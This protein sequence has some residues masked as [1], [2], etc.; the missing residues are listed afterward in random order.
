MRT[1]HHQKF[2]FLLIAL[3]ILP[4]VLH[5]PIW[6]SIISIALVFYKSLGEFFPIPVPRRIFL[7][8]AALVSTVLVYRHF[9]T[10]AGD[11]ASTALLLILVSLKLF[12]VR[13]YRD[14]MIMI[15]LCFFLLLTK[16]LADQSIPT[17]IYLV[18]DVILIL[19]FLIFCHSEGQNVR[20]RHLFTHSAGLVTLSLPILLGLFFIFPRFSF[21]LFQSPQKSVGRV[22]LS[23]EMD[24]GSISSVALSDELIFRAYFPGEATPPAMSELY[25]RAAILDQGRGLSWR[26]SGTTKFSEERASQAPALSETIRQEIIQEPSGNRFLFGMDWP[27]SLRVSGDAR[28]RNAARRPGGVFESTLPIHDRLY[29]EVHS[30]GQAIETIRTP[31]LQRYLDPGPLTESERSALQ[32]LLEEHLNDS[33]GDTTT[34]RVKRLLQYFSEQGFQYT[35][36]PGTLQSLDEFLFEAQ[37]GFCEHYAAATATILR[38][39]KIPARVVIGFQGGTPSLLGD[40]ILVRAMDAHAWVEY[41]DGGWKRLD[42]TSVV[43]P[44]RLIGGGQILRYGPEGAEGPALWGEGLFSKEVNRWLLKAGLFYDQM[45]SAWLSFLLRYDGSYQREL[46]EHF[47][48]RRWSKPVLFV[49]AIAFA[50]II[51]WLLYRILHH[52]R[53]RRRP[54]ELLS[55]YHRLCRKLESLGVRRRPNEGPLDFR[56]RAIAATSDKDGELDRIFSEIIEARYGATGAQAVDLRALRKRIR[57]LS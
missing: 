53:N 48:L 46:L 44:E 57:K 25:W 5:V 15:L 55:T 22:G 16:L 43:A 50:L 8:G 34:A 38:W 36:T 10:L 26:R 40:Y 20:M 28:N 49:V 19:A 14:V 51:G 29:Y 2:L 3:N 27:V 7:N 33:P 1:T 11:E 39:M 45:E 54:D 32:S 24:P 13:S 6:V 35:L 18:A 31:A 12:E 47:G 30:V 42:P 17:T 52:F 21:G 23:E 37:R 9:E 41:W 4:H 56:D